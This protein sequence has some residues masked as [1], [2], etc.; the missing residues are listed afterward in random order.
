[1]LRGIINTTP[2]LMYSFLFMNPIAQQIEYEIF[3][4]E[5]YIMLWLSENRLNGFMI[6]RKTCWYG[7]S[8]AARRFKHSFLKRNSL[9]NCIYMKFLQQK[10]VLKKKIC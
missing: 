6:T 5:L 9:Q 1:M 7:I 4:S 10:L 8:N 2:E 3:P